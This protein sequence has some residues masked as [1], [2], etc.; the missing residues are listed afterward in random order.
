MEP[1]PE[2]GPQA[3]PLAGQLEG[4]QLGRYLVRGRLG[5]GGVAVVYQAYDQVMGRT[6]ALKL[7]PPNTDAGTIDRFR[8]EALMAGALRHPHIVRI[9]QVGTS[10][11]GGPAYMAMEYVEGETLATLIARVG[12]LGPDESCRLLEPVARALGFAHRQ[13]IV[14]RDVK[15]SNILLRPAGPGVPN[16]V[17]I[18]A[19]EYPIVPLL[20][21]FGVARFL[22]APEL[23]STGRTV[24]TPAFMA[25]EQC[26]GS[27]DVDG[28][29]DV[30]A[31]G[32]VLYRCVV[33]R[34]P[35]SGTTT[36]V[37]HAQVY[38]PVTID[39]AILDDL[40]GPVVAI[41]R[42][43]LAKLPEERH[44]SADA[45]ADDLIAAAQAWRGQRQAV[46][47][48]GSDATDTITLT[49]AMPVATVTSASTV[50][51]LVAGNSRATAQGVSPSGPATDTGA[52]RP[53]R[54]WAGIAAGAAVVA[55]MVA[56]AAVTI[57]SL[58]PTSRAGREP[59]PGLA[60]LAP[61]PDS[62][63]PQA[64]G[65]TT[66]ARAAG[67]VIAPSGSITQP[68]HDTGVAAPPTAA[69]I[70]AL[71]TTPRPSP[72]AALATEP[73]AAPNAAAGVPPTVAP[74][75]NATLPAIVA[76]ATAA[77]TPR[78]MEEPSEAPLPVAPSVP[79]EEE[80]PA[81]GSPPTMAPTTSATLPAIVATA[82]AT[83]TPLPMEEP[84]E[85]PL[86][87]ASPV[88]PGEESP[89]AGTEMAVGACT[90]VVDEGFLGALA[91]IDGE[92]RD[93]LGCPAG[94]PDSA[95]A[96]YLPFERGY[97][98]RLSNSPLIYVSYLATGE[99]EQVVESTAP[100]EQP[101]S[102][103]TPGEGPAP[104]APFAGVWQANQRRI[105]LGAPQASAPTVYDARL[106][107][108]AGGILVGA[109]D[110]AGEDAGLVV[111][112]RSKLRL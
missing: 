93:Q 82:A 56:L 85:A 52:R 57:P 9:F 34:L 7:L 49:A 22:D 92:V 29:A 15:P 97:M 77:P 35:F 13:G 40:P 37:L 71:A 101:G 66:T 58:Y 94:P 96:E 80:S 91:A 2:H 74:T 59:A 44:A 95:V 75:A 17:Q 72:S 104:P 106:Q 87:V 20:S 62:P 10:P 60:V 23:T 84:L 108:F 27:R 21:D 73:T 65:E 11:H 51:E 78:P 33:G 12:Q 86:P 18:D 112:L 8:R 105:A 14:H 79:P 53:S 111:F 26:T 64:A 28:R 70:A 68:E 1:P 81:A 88:P 102:Q 25:P 50:V 99:W 110:G 89:A 39:A 100:G 5:G 30:Y 98:L 36:Q 3:Y 61:P 67:R 90:N 76:T 45:L 41:L 38:D 16:S 31:L 54:R 43:S 48:R 63:T 103:S 24:G 4:Q 83:P 32:T 6:V 109:I 46:L 55:L 107:V 47:P 19:L 42:K 69:A